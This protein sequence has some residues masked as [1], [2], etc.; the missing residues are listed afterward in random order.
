M[1]KLFEQLLIE[2]QMD[3]SYFHNLQPRMT[4]TDTFIFCTFCV[5]A[6]FTYLFI[7]PAVASNLM[8]TSVR[9]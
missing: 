2:R 7:R 5:Q 3:Q 1:K 4:S 8:K 9:F 6:Y